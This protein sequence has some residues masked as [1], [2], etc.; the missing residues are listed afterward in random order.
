M[1]FKI[2]PDSSSAY[3]TFNIPYERAAEIGNQ[4]AAIVS[5][6]AIN[7]I[8]EYIVTL[9]ENGEVF[10]RL[11]FGKLIEKFLSISEDVQEKAFILYTAHS[12]STFI[13]NRAGFDITDGV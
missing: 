2:N 8:D 12:G 6:I 11:K 10:G 9:E 3:E 7:N 4:L 5:D 13:L 1:N